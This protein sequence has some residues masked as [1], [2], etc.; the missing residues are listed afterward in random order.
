[1][2]CRFKYYVRVVSDDRAAVPTADLDE[3]SEEEL[4]EGLYIPTMERFSRNPPEDWLRQKGK[5]NK[6]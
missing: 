2:K 3:L 1:M 6:K 4:G 5:N